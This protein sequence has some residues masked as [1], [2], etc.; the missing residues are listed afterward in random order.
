MDRGRVHRIGALLLGFLGVVACRD[1]GFE[2]LEEV[3]ETSCV[4]MPEGALHW[5]AG[6]GTGADLIG[7]QDVRLVHGAE[8]AR[9]L[10]ASGNGEAFRFDGV[11][12]MGRVS[13]APTLNPTGP[14]SVMAWARPGPRPTSSG[15][16]IGKGNPWAE[17]WVLDSHRG[18]WRG[19]MRS[20]GGRDAR[21]YGPD[22]EPNV[23]THVAMS[24]DGAWFALYV[25]GDLWG[26]YP[27]D[28]LHRSDAFVGI[29]AR[30]EAGFVDSELEVE[31]AGDIDEIVFFGRALGR[32]EIRVVFEA[33]KAG[34]CKT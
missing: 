15:T 13:D 21:G 31:F 26:S 17:S 6:D 4:P 11:D 9:G 25:N 18:R 29:G 19:F 30:S 8:Y 20:A 1:M 16:I 12:A 22:L 2:A 23:W 7:G 33:S 10:V 3:T 32:E 14:F 24:W 28:T 34:I 27:L 5:W